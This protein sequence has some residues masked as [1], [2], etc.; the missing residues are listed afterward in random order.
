MNTKR[1]L[2]IL[3]DSAIY[4]LL[5]LYCNGPTHGYK[6]IKDI[7]VISEYGCD[8]SSATLYRIVDRFLLQGL[9]K[10]Y[11]EFENVKVYE[12]TLAGINT[13]RQ[14][15]ARLKAQCNILETNLNR[16]YTK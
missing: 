16:D 8:I 9:I 13:L 7:K 3:S 10:I 1:R 6:L 11:D 5:S 2:P 15:Y 4:V 14:Q 12:I